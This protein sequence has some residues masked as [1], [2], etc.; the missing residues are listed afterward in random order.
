MNANI[1]MK[2]VDENL[3]NQISSDFYISPINVEYIHGIA[4]VPSDASSLGF[5]LSNVLREIVIYA[6][7][8]VDRD[9][10]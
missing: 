4:I 7:R 8:N 1:T 10:Q 3:Y 6:T 2:M 5:D 9:H